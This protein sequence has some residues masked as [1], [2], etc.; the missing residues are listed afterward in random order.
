MDKTTNSVKDMLAMGTSA[1]ELLDSLREEIERA[2]AE[3]NAENK[4][5]AKAKE[6]GLT[7]AREALAA[8]LMDYIVALDILPAEVM[9]EMTME[10]A[11]EI[12]KSVENEI[13]TYTSIA[14]LA[15]GLGI[16][17]KPASRGKKA[18]VCKCKEMTPADEEIIREFLKS[19][20]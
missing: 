13:V 15:A 10:D 14:S 12:I 1:E 18:N 2:Q 7:T 3:I 6:T 19:L 4:A 11:I 16:E 17:P 5:K 20:S 8:T 9:A